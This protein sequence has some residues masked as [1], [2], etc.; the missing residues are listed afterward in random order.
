ML[1]THKKS[2]EED[3]RGTQGSRR[4]KLYQCIY[5]GERAQHRRKSSGDGL[6]TRLKLATRQQWQPAVHSLETTSKPQSSLEASELLAGDSSRQSTTD[7][8]KS[9]QDS[10]VDYCLL[11]TYTQ[12]FGTTTWCSRSEMFTPS[13]L[14]CQKKESTSRIPG[15]SFY[16]YNKLLLVT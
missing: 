4:S 3:V 15:G 2:G 10:F 14:K 7:K 8:V 1:S 13:S 5:N 11:R 12:R 16:N 9:T 6:A